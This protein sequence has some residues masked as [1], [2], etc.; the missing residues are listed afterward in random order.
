M[1]PGKRAQECHGPCC[2]VVCLGLDESDEVMVDATGY[3]RHVLA[4]VVEYG[5]EDLRHGK[6]V[7]V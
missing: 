1:V 4:G 5:E 6:D 2:G 3:D 7:I